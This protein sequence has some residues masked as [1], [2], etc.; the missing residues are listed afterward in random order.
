MVWWTKFISTIIRGYLI[1]QHIEILVNISN[2][3]PISLV[4][5][6]IIWSNNGNKLDYKSDNLK[7]E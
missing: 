7:Y 1:V 2:N 4:S 5:Q 3:K 6:E